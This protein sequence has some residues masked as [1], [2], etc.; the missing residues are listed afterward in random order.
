MRQEHVFEKILN[1]ESSKDNRFKCFKNMKMKH[2]ST[3]NSSLK[4][5]TRETHIERKTL[6]IENQAFMDIS[7]INKHNKALILMAT[8]PT[9]KNTQTNNKTI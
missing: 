5:N 4:H 7:Q 8:Y 2:L 9:I 1:H 3:T 6:V